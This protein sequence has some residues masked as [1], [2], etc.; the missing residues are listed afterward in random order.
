MQDKLEKMLN[1]YLGT[2]KC[3]LFYVPVLAIEE[4]PAIDKILVIV[5]LSITEQCI[6]TLAPPPDFNFAFGIN[7]ARFG[8]FDVWDFDGIFSFTIW[9]TCPGGVFV[10]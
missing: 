8:Y 5:C 7:P 9:R 4:K 10:N 3:Y 2:K 6:A 1:L